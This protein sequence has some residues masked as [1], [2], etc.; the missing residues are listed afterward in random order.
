MWKGTKNPFAVLF[1]KPD[2]GS[3]KGDCRFGK[4]LPL[5]TDPLPVQVIKDCP[6]GF[7]GIN[8]ALHQLRGKGIT[9]VRPSDI[10]KINHIKPRRFG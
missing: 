2:H 4:E 3:K 5:F 10:I 6:G 1:Q 8:R 7:K 9:A